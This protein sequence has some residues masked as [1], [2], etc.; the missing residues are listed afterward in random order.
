MNLAIITQQVKKLRLSFFG[1]KLE[2]QN[3]KFIPR[4]F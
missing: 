1:M 4:D 2:I 3:K